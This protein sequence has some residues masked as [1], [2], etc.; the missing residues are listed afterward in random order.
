MPTSCAWTSIRSRARASSR[1]ARP[2]RSSRRCWTSSASSPFPRRPA[3]ADCT[4]TSACSRAGTPTPCAP[5]RWPP[6]ASSSAGAPTSSPPRGGRRSAASGSSSTTTRTRRTRRSSARGR[7]ARGR[8]RRSR[9]R[10]A[11]RS[12][13]TSHPDE[14]TLASVPAPAGARRRSV[15]RHR[16]RAAVA[17]AA[18]GAARARPRERPARRAVA[19]GLPQAARRAAAR[20][21]EPGPPRGVGLRRPRGA[22]LNRR[23]VGRL[24]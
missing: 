11:G 10:C 8:A 9:R 17:R 5:P 12:S 15:G 18:A 13:T 16:R 24:S 6:R 14:L 2:P 4:S 20:R 22:L 23:F 21:A 7:C 1:P 19:A 3:T